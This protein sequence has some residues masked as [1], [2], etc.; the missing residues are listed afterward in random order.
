[1]SYPFLLPQ[2]PPLLPGLQ[3]FLDTGL[4]T[5]LS[6][7]AG[8]TR[9]AKPICR[10]FDNTAVSVGSPQKSGQNSENE[11]CLQRYEFIKERI[12]EKK[13]REN[14]LSTKRKGEV[15][16]KRKKTG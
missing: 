12:L 10:S 6:Q 11:F 8:W 14:T 5:N 7:S 15:Q 4:T 16:E 3:N 9:Q 13:G 1:M 2:L